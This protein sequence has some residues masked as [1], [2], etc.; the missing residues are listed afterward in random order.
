MWF[1]VAPFGVLGVAWCGSVWFAVWLGLAWP[2]LASPGQARPGLTWLGLAW[3]GVRCRY[4]NQ[5]KLIYFT[6]I[7]HSSNILYF[8]TSEKVSGVGPSFSDL[9]FFFLGGG[10]WPFLLGVGPSLSFVLTMEE[11]NCGITRESYFQLETK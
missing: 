10:I 4:L 9:F 5:A 8:L 3:L 1:C 6:S 2:G 11:I 7:Y